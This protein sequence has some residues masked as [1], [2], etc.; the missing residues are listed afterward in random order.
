MERSELSRRNSARDSCMRL[1]LGARRPTSGHGHAGIGDRP[2]ETE[3]IGQNS[4]LN[5]CIGQFAFRHQAGAFW[6][7]WYEKVASLW[8][9]GQAEVASVPSSDWPAPS[10]VRATPWR[11]S[12]HPRCEADSSR[13]T[14]SRSRSGRRCQIW[15]A[16]GA[17]P[18]V[19]RW[20]LRPDRAQIPWPASHCARGRRTADRCLR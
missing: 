3:H 13:C 4:Q 6:K 15:K 16:P 17:E 5:F 2:E 10:F 11:V 18:V 20:W 19:T 1:Y 14:G 12:A 8:L 7:M 9:H